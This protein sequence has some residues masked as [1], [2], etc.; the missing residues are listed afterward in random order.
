LGTSVLEDS[1]GYPALLP[2]ESPHPGPLALLEEDKEPVALVHGELTRGVVLER[3]ILSLFREWFQVGLGHPGLDACLVV[4]PEP[5]LELRGAPFTRDDLPLGKAEGDSGLGSVLL[6]C[7]DKSQGCSGTARRSSQITAPKGPEQAASFYHRRTYLQGM[8]YGK[9]VCLRALEMQDLDMMVAAQ[10][11]LETR[12]WGGVPVAK[13]RTAVERW[14]QLATVADPWRDGAVYFAVT[15]K[16][17]GRF[18]GTVRL[19]DIKVPHYRASVGIA[20]HST[21]ERGKGYGA[22]ATRV[23]LWVGFHVLGLHSVYLDTMEHNDRAIH[24]AEKVGFTRVGVF[25]ETE[26]INGEY[27]GLVYYD[28]LREEFDGLYP[29]LDCGRVG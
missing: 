6:V 10:N 7:S 19:Y 3:G 15:D 21:D 17:D 20:V 4:A 14:L 29:D 5:P 12:R 11:D 24:A 25:R 28:I 16:Q 1:K 26:F 18:L 22:D 13:S 2:F 9:L 27:R 23:A 8:Y